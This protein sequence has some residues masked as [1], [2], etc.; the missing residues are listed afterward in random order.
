MLTPR[1][2]ARL[3][4]AVRSRLI[5][6]RQHLRSRIVL[7][8]AD[9]LPDA[10]IARR[11]QIDKRTVRLWRERFAREGLDALRRDAPR[12]GRPSRLGD[13]VWGIAR[14]L[15]DDGWRLSDIARQ[16]AVSAATVSRL[17]ARRRDL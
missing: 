4:R 13:D 6:V 12:T 16:L 5:P 7:M 14:Q 10:E 1:D 9:G 2:R 11:L 3:Q 17:L 8:A 15:R